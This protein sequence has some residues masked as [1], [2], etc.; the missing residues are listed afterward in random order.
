MSFARSL[1]MRMHIDPRRIEVIDDDLADVLRKMGRMHSIEMVS[2][3][4]RSMIRAQTCR[5]HPD[6]DDVQI[7]REV[8]RSMANGRT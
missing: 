3:G 5:L 4:W 7:E 8:S 2:S 1:Y 6:W